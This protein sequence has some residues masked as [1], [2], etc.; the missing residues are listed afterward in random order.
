MSDTDIVDAVPKEFWATI[1]KAAQD[2]DRFRNLLQKMNQGQIIRF[3]W[4]YEE[5]ASRI[6]TDR[7][8]AYV[9]PNLSEDELDELA[10]WVVA[11]GKAYY[12]K[13]LDQPDQIPLKK[14]DVG[15]L[16]AVVEEY[17]QRFNEDIPLNLREWDNEW[18]Q[19]GKSSP[20]A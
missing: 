20:W 7:H 4:T 19:H 12:R 6:T 13:I 17:K 1:K 2:P 10:N 3:Y 8:L 9:H 5:L 14:N 16:I 15:L 18:R 11:Q